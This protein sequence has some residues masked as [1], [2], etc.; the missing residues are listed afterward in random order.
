[1]VFQFE[2]SIFETLI[3]LLMAGM[4]RSHMALPRGHS[5][6]IFLCLKFISLD[7][8]T[9]GTPYVLKTFLRAFMAVSDVRLFVC[10]TMALRDRSQTMTKP[11]VPDGDF[12][13]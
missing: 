7:F 3:A 5:G 10:S 4:K 13:E 11:Y 6:V 9:Q 8:S 1:M 12:D 2:P